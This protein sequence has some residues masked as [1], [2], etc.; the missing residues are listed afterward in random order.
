MPAPE[1]RRLSG[2]GVFGRIGQQGDLTCTLDGSRNQPLVSCTS[3]STSP[4]HDTAALSNEPSQCRDI[5][6]IQSAHLFGA[7]RASPRTPLEISPG[8]ERTAFFGIAPAVTFAG[9]PFSISI[10]VIVIGQVTS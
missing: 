5:L 9:R 6:I 10:A 4:W 3:S 7:K 1:R 8:T 2:A